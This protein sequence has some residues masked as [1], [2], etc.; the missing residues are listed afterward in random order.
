MLLIQLQMGNTR[1]YD[2]FFKFIE[3]YC[4]TGFT[5][6]DPDDPLMRKLEDMMKENKQFFFIGDMIQMKIL[7]TSKRSTLMF[8]VEPEKM[9][10]HSFFEATH[11][12]DIQRHSLG[13][14]NMIKLSHDLFIAEMGSVLLSSSL[15]IRNP[16]GTYSLILFQCYAFYSASPSKTTYL[17]QIHTDI[18]WCKKIK[19]GHHYYMGSDLS[20]FKYPDEKMLCEGNVFSDREFEII[21]LAEK[22]MG[23]E[24]IAQ[25]LFLSTH[26]INTHR[27]NILK[28]TGKASIPELIHDLRERGVI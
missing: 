7:Y 8:G 9:N 2:L 26:T 14:S 4:P 23:S 18:G 3:K 27:R 5:G 28:K 19:H 17:L 10:P 16:L 6:I 25:R 1:S 12:E 15:K 24:Q 22:G 20:Y 11:P 13:R 21:K